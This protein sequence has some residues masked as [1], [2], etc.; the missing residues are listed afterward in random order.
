MMRIEQIGVA[1]RLLIDNDVCK[2]D[3]MHV[4]RRVHGLICACS[5]RRKDESLLD[6]AAQRGARAA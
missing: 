6:E 3:G 2:R 5:V 4:R 1:M